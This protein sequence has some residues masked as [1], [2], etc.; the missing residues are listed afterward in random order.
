MDVSQEILSDI[1]V[2]MKYAR[3][4]PELKR[5]ET[6]DEICE[7]NISMHIKRFPELAGEIR[8]VYSRFVKTKKVLPSMRSM[9]FAGKPIDV[10]PARIYNC[11]FLP[12]DSIEAFS[13][14]M[15]LLLGGTGVGYSVQKFHV[16]KL[17]ILQGV[18]KPEGRQRK[19][20][21]LVGDSIEGWADA[22]KSLM[23]SYFYGKKELDFDFRDIRPKGARLITAG[24]KAPGPEP[25]RRCIAN[26]TAILENALQDRGRGT[27]LKPLEVHDIV[28]H[29]ADAVLAGGIRRASLLSL[30]SKDDKEMLFCKTGAW[31]EKNPQRGRSNNSACFVRGVARKKDFLDFWEIVKNSGSGEPGIYWTNDPGWGVNPCQP[32][33]AT[34]LTPNGIS[35]IGKVK[36]GDKIW[37]EDGWVTITKKWSTGVKEVY[38]YTTNYGVFCGTENHRVVSKGDKKEV[39]SA[40]YIDLLGGPPQKYVHPAIDQ[41]PEATIT[42][43]AVKFD[44]TPCQFN[45]YEDEEVCCFT[46]DVREKLEKVQLELNANGILWRI[47]E[48]EKD[49]QRVHE[50][51]KYILHCWGSNKCGWDPAKQDCRVI[52]SKKFSDEEVFDITV[53]GPSHTYWTGGCNVSNCCEIALRPTQFCVSG[54]TKLITKQ[55]IEIIQNC[56]GKKVEI[57]N[58][59]QWSEVEPFQTG[60]ADKLYRVSF[61]DGSYLDA[62]SDHKFLVKHRF[63]KDFAK[64]TTLELMDLL[65]TS[66]YGL[67]IPRADV[68]YTGRV[69][70]EEAYNYGFFL[71]D[72]HL[73]TQNKGKRSA[74]CNLYGKKRELEHANTDF[75][76]TKLKKWKHY[77]TE[78]TIIKYNFDIELAE[79]IKEGHGLPSI[80]FTWNKHSILQ[81]IAGWADSDGSQASKGIRI[82]GKEEKL[83]DAQLL[84]TKVGINS[85]LNLMSKKGEVTNMGVRNWDIWYL[86]ITVTH[87]IPCKR[88]KC[89]NKASGCKGKNQI[90]RSIRALEGLHPSYCLTEPHLHQCVFNNVL[91]SNCNLVEV[92]AGDIESQHELNERAKAAAFMATLQAGYTDFHY[93]KDSWRENTEKDALLGVSMTGIGSGKVLAFDLTEASKVVNDENARIADF[94]GINR[95]ARQTCIKPAGTTSLTLGCSSGIHAWHA[96]FYL[97]RIR[98]MKNESIYTYLKMYH[99]ELV[100]DE[101]FSP[102][103]TA[104]IQVPQRAPAGSLMRDESPMTTLARVKRFSEEWVANGHFDGPNQHNVSCT[105]S[106]KE[107]EW[108]EVGEWMWKHRHIYNG[109]SVLPYDGGTYI[110]APFEDITEERFNEL[111]KSLSNVDL[112]KIVEEEDHTDLSGE[113]ACA[114]GACV[115]T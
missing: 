85:S 113:L 55:G 43:L 7:R 40:E 47:H 86:Q 48:C 51:N 92:N 4:L 24:G 12:I 9:Q 5:R 107:D 94:I 103:D 20:R 109:I 74:Y 21:F 52:S 87:E 31:W 27:K 102:H 25:L 26:I 10:N 39:S 82:Y 57:W 67:Y 89:I 36:E 96:P 58:G 105:L 101:F 35:T 104:V 112:T 66:K 45:T 42:E 73:T 91:T 37:S 77:E 90:V 6:W 13:E 46:S 59:E 108:D 29:I 83:R 71:G 18:L 19:K 2:Y 95:A 50:V 93:L 114:G 14:T 76:G 106:I 81:F 88:L 11:A 49:D 28:C 111:Y 3:Y 115:V 53:D 79:K 78:C 34:V 30:F 70:E 110:Q 60:T 98:V 15:F 1:T 80:L 63:Q 23:E 75:R 99:P 22:I 17:P 38:K 100:E 32:A 41:L 33:W 61:G 72:G 65:K 97:R 62:T 68:Q 84:L 64:V 56:V 8:D 54:D 69:Y 16:D 44:V